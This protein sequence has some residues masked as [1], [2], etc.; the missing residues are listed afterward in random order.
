MY[1]AAIVLM[2]V[3]LPLCCV[4]VEHRVDGAAWTF[5]IGKW[6]VFWAVGVRVFLA[7][8]MQ[9]A[10]PQFTA[11]RIFHFETDDA[12]PIVRELGIA[13]VAGGLVA[14][15][16][17]ANPTFVLPIAIW[18]AIFYG[19]ASVAHIF[20]RERAAS[21]TVAM[22]TDIFAFVVLLAIV[23]WSIF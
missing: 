19:G 21:E 1:S 2:M 3:V 22:A 18:A 14:I 6:F 11:H 12:L 4:L 9:L 17:I 8:V 20:G 13:N 15:V 7:G 5:L 16:S 10:R 23:A